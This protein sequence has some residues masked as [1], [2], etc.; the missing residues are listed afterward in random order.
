MCITF[1]NKNNNILEITLYFR[2]YR[3]P[4][5]TPAFSWWARPSVS[6]SSS[7]TKRS[8]ACFWFW[9]FGRGAKNIERVILSKLLETLI[10]YLSGVFPIHQI[11]HGVN[12]QPHRVR[13]TY[14]SWCIEHYRFHD[15]MGVCVWSRHD[16]NILIV[17]VQ[18]TEYVDSC[19]LNVK[20]LIFNIIYLQQIVGQGTPTQEI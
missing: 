10:I 19:S 6:R 5:Q 16:D 1:N 12:I 15:G 14:E 3:A 8:Q 13:I 11:Q 20:Y 7:E 9:I 4:T 18:L 17:V 2:K